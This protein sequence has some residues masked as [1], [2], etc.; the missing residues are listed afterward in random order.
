MRRKSLLGIAA[1]ATIAAAL[2]CAGG[3]SA[4]S[5]GGTAAGGADPTYYNVP[6]GYRDLHAGMNGADVQTLNW[7]LRGLGLGT[8]YDGAFQSVTDG[9]V[10]NLQAGAGLSANGV[11]RLETRK[12]LASRML[13][14]TASWYG[15][16]FYG[17]RTACGK[18]LTKR[19]VGVAHRRLPCGTRVA[20][21][22]GG[23]W[24]RAKVIDRGPYIKG[25]KWDLTRALALQLGTV[26][27]GTAVVKA[28]VAP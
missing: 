11:V 28:A 14:Q 13:N 24:V 3:A 8:G 27:L 4:Q 6:F 10:R 18:K 1:A 23:R 12:A 17:N 5:P 7:V 19:T 26:P 21:A 2:A 9:A 25:R 20:F 16:A 22:Y 15:P